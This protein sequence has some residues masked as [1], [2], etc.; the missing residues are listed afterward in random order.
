MHAGHL[1]S[2]H[3]ESHLNRVGESKP[4]HIGRLSLL[5]SLAE[6]D[7]LIL[8]NQL[9][10]HRN[11]NGYQLPCWLD[12]MEFRLKA[13]YYLFYTI[14]FIS[15]A[16][17]AVSFV[18][19]LNLLSNEFYRPYRNFDGAI[20]ALLLCLPF[21]ILLYC[22][23]FLHRRKMTQFQEFV[24][25]NG[26]AQYISYVNFT[27]IAINSSSNRIFLA[28]CGDLAEHPFSDVR[29]FEKKEAKGRQVVGG[30][31]QGAGANI[32]EAIWA[33]DNTGIFVFVKD[34][35]RPVWH[36]RFQKKHDINRWFEILQQNIS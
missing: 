35:N 23:Y 15:G 28:S 25:N 26:G 7:T 9:W 11:G 22:R 6:S 30:G 13:L 5:R 18:V 1:P 12:Q 32:G 3:G 20:N 4:I 31:M 29:S 33:A 36:V 14:L 21:I 27:G 10:C 24:N 17:A 8:N 2:L 34:V 16:V 19:S